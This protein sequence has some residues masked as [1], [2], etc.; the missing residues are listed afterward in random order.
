MEGM[1]YIKTLRSKHPKKLG[2]STT[3]TQLDPDM[4]SSSTSAV[5]PT[6]FQCNGFEARDEWAKYGACNSVLFFILRINQ[7]LEE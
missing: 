4:F 6:I 7:V 1:V 5:G 3:Q 2:V